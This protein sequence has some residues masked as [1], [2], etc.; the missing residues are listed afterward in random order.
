M[1]I[2]SETISEFY[3]GRKKYW[4]EENTLP[5]IYKF[6]RREH[7]QFCKSQCEDIASPDIVYMAVPVYTPEVRRQIKV[8]V[9]TSAAVRRINATLD[10]GAGVPKSPIV[11]SL[12]VDA[13]SGAP[14]G[15]CY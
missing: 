2:V 10:V 1:Q 4:L 11:R 9:E 3:D 12:F 7:F 15:E 6:D 8:A 14:I 13:V 5:P